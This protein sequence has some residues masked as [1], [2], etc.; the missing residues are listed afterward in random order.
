M[1]YYLQHLPDEST[2]AT[3]MLH[4]RQH[5]NKRGLHIR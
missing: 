1:L 2:S 4:K 5:L 3:K